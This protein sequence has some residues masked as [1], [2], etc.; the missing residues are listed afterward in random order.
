MDPLLFPLQKY[1]SVSLSPVEACDLLSYLVLDT[2]FHTKDHGWLDE[3]IIHQAQLC[4]KGLAV[5]FAHILYV[6]L[7]NNVTQEIM[8]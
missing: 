8:L 5:L 3:T 6:S 7:V 4:L 2:S 1:T